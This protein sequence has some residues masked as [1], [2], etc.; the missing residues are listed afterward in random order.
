MKN[1]P[2]VLGNSEID[3]TGGGA[4]EPDS[5]TLLMDLLKAL[6]IGVDKTE[7]RDVTFESVFF[8]FDSTLLL[9]SVVFKLIDSFNDSSMIVFLFRLRYKV[10]KMLFYSM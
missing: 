2:G 8:R 4:G 3:L 1:L 7:A 5:R 6:A 10:M 9:L